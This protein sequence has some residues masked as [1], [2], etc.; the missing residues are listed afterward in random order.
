MPNHPSGNQV[1][2]T[3]NDQLLSGTP[4]DAQRKNTL[5]WIDGECMS[6]INANLQSNG[7]WLLSWL[8][9][10]QCNT[11]VRLHAKDTDFVRLDNSVFKVPFTKD[12]IGKK[13]YIKFCSYN[14]FGAGNQDLSEVKAY[15]YTLTPYYIPP[16][17]NLTAYNRYRQLADGVSRYDIVVNW[18]PPELQSYLQGDVWYKT[19][20]GQAKDLVIKEGT[21]GSELGF[22]GE[23]TFGGSG[24]D[25]VV[26]PQAIVGD[27]YLIAVCTKDEWGESTSPDTSP[28]MKILVALK[29][30]IP[31]TPD[32]FD[33]NFG[34]ACIASWK[35]VTNT[36]VAFYEVRR[37]IAQ[38]LKR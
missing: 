38:A 6:Y 1:F 35:E 20:N 12:D 15:E 32:G 14:I 34:T 26:I 31:N 5:C 24:K 11:E 30:E 36:D 25:Q 10:G 9:R 21:K 8:Y 2:V 28:Q 18:T 27:T 17:T 23:W 3:C 4:Q 29:T 37:M 16:V 33:I 22:D 7:A 13:I 19:S